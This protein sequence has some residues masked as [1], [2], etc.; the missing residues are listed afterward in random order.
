MPWK[1]AS[2]MS[3][4]KG[5]VEQAKKAGANIS[6]LCRQFGISRKTGYKW[7]KRER[8]E[9]IAGLMDR[10]HRPH[11]SPGQTEAVMEEHVLAVREENPVWGGRKIRQVLEDAGY[12]RVPSAS[13]I[14]AILQRNQRIDAEESHK[15]TAFKRFEKEQPNE[16]WQMD[17]KGYFGMGGGGYC[18]PLTVVDDHSRFLLGLRACPNERAQTV[19]TQ[20]TDLFRQFGLPERMLMDNGSPWGDDREAPYTILGAWLLRLGI[21]ISHG[22]PYHP[23]TQGKDERFN[24]T[25]KEELIQRYTL[26]DLEECQAAFDDW[27]YTY[28]YIRPH[29]AL[30]LRPPASRYHSSSHPFP[31]FL[32]PI[33]YDLADFVRKVDKSGKIYFHNHHFQVGKAFRYQPVALR[34]TEQDGLF[35]VFFCQQKVAQINLREDN[36]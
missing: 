19:Q 21:A 29:D 26:V 22:R 28:N 36:S 10:S 15:H 25:L 30:A 34:H 7:L 17:F 8:A 24:R 32:P 11:S 2:R 5:F 13:T 9:G 23:Q 12:Q 3:L 27:W 33:V 35:H 20:L 1:E 16:L 6:V 31:E 14:T 4:R 18:H